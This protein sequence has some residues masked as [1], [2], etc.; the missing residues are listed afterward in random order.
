MSQIIGEQHLM[1]LNKTANFICETFDEFEHDRAKKEKIINKVQNNMSA[2]I[3]SSKGR[4][5]RQE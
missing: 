3:E 5:D 1:D 2:V 4:L